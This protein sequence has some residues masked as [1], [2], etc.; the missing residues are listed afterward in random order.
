MRAAPFRGRPLFESDEIAIDVL[1]RFTGQGFGADAARWGRWL[2]KNRWV[3]HAAVDDPRRTR[4][5]RQN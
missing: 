2:R 5:D 1:R 4:R 3:Y